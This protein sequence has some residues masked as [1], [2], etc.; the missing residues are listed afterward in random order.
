MSAAG[1]NYFNSFIRVAA[2]CP[3]AEGID[4]RDGKRLTVAV[5]QFELLH[6]RPHELTSEDVLFETSKAR[7]ELGDGAPA[8][9]VAAA[10]AAFFGRPQACLRASPLPRR[11]GWGLHLDEQ[12][13]IA[14]VAVGTEEYR[15]H[16]EDPGLVQLAAF[17]SSRA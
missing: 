12:G 10:R 3:V 2:D 6:G 1:V 4:P 7:A 13:R 17:R 8:A 5:R 9:V 14:L 15:R 16:A 11:F